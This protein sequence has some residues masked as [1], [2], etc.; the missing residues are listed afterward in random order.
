MENHSKKENQSD[1]VLSGRMSSLMLKG[2]TEG[3]N[4]VRK[5]VHDYEVYIVKNTGQNHTLWWKET[6]I[7]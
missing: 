3:K 5:P 6:S 1:R 4:W 7:E 2:M